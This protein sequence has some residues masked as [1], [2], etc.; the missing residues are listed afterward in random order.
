MIYLD[1]H[2]VAWLFAGRIE[3]IPPNTQ[4]KFLKE[5]LFISPMVMLELQFLY[6]IGRVSKKSAQVIHDLENRINLKICEIPF[7]LVILDA[8]NQKWTRDPFDRIIVAQAS[9]N[10]STLVTK[11]TL[12]Q[13]NYTHAY[14]K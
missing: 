13:K 1:T 5:D 10:S 3:L 6:E 14:W 7:P 2:V 8:Q 11:D 12:I 9:I 4:E